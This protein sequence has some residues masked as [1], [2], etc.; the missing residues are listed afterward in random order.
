MT[1]VINEP[2]MY[3]FCIG[4]LIGAPIGVVAMIAFVNSIYR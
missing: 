4:V 2:M 1:I 3:S